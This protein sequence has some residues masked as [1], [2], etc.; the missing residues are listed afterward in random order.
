MG[1]TDVLLSLMNSDNILEDLMTL[2]SG[3]DGFLEYYFGEEHPENT[4]RVY[5]DEWIP[6]YNSITV[7]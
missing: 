7:G 6:F 3:E 2:D 5:D 4:N 1:R